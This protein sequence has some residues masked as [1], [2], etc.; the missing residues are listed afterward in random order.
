[1]TQLLITIGHYWQVALIRRT[2]VESSVYDAQAAGNICNHT[3]TPPSRLAARLAP[4][5]LADRW[6]IQ[7]GGLT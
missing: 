3:D 1:M 4:K 7:G 2:S 6:R 5:K